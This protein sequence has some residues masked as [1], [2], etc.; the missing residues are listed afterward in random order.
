M[1]LTMQQN[2]S[3]QTKPVQRLNLMDTLLYLVAASA[4]TIISISFLLWLRF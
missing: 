1:E 3:G 4:M 2:R